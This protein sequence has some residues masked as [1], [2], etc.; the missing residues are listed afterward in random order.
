M[1]ETVS[2]FSIFISRIKGSSNMTWVWF[3]PEGETIFQGRIDD[4]RGRRGRKRK[5]IMI[6][7]PPQTSLSLTKLL[8]MFVGWQT[9]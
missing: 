3:S 6:E 7:Y 8:E 5:C 9:Y 4:L 2:T 1:N